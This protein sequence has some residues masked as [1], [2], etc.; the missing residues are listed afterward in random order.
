MRRRY[1]NDLELRFGALIFTRTHTRA[2]T[3]TG[4]ILMMRETNLR[5]AKFVYAMA[6]YTGADT[7]IQQSS[8]LGGENKLKKS[9]IFAVVDR[10]LLGMVVRVVCCVVML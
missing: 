7:K 1:V 8:K 5:N 10:C 6:V 2:D 4:D 9:R 3:H